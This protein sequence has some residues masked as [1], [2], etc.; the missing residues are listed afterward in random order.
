M[1]AD[2]PVGAGPTE[3]YTK[4]GGIVYMNADGSFHYVAPI[5]KHGEAANADSFSYRVRY[6]DGTLS[7]LIV[8]T[9]DLLD[10]KPAAEDDD[11][12]TYHLQSNVSVVDNDVL[13]KDWIEGIGNDEKLQNIVSQVRTAE[14]AAEVSVP[15]DS[16]NA[17]DQPLLATENGGKVWVNQD[18]TF[19][20]EAAVDFVG[21]D[22]FQYQLN[23]ADGTPSGWA[24][25][26][27]DV[28]NMVEGGADQAELSGTED[29]DVFQWSLADLKAADGESVTNTVN[30]FN[31]DEG[32]KL[33]L[34]D[35]LKDGDDYLFDTD[36]LGVTVNDS[37]NTVI[38]VKP[39]DESAPDLNIEIVGDLTGGYQG[40][41]AIDQ[42]IKNGNLIND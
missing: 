33:D 32:D 35:L 34:R 15:E 27:I 4:M 26:T 37:G 9:I 5:I 31:P 6:A 8:A 17:G 24:T 19:D 40:Q 18:G 12:A 3:F 1:F 2:K 22:T 7:A 16:Y 23:D 39:V 20:Y 30:N 29:A 14:G 42:L 13:S 11:Y 38:A 36:H 10:T 25:V 41:D 28:P 21:K